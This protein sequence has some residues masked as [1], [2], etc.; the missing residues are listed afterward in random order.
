MEEKTTDLSKALNTEELESYLESHSFGDYESMNFPLSLDKIMLANNI[1]ASH[2]IKN[3]ALSKSYI[4][5]IISGS[6]TPSRDKIL[7]I[8][9][10]MSIGLKDC[11]TLLKSASYRELH[12]K[13]KR[14]SIIIYAINKK[15][16]LTET[17]IRLDAAGCEI[18][19]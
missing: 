19:K 5:A 7:M 14:D 18:V 12:P 11:N 4:Y 2:I 6:K 17:N 13:S 3:S 15:Y 16:S 9:L 8:S 1:K 10:A